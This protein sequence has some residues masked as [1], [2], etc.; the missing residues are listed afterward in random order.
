MLLGISGFTAPVVQKPVQQTPSQKKSAQKQSNVT[1]IAQKAQTADQ[2]I[3][4]R[5]VEKTVITTRIMNTDESIKCHN[6]FK[7]TPESSD[8]KPVKKAPKDDPISKKGRKRKRTL[9]QEMLIKDF[10]QQLEEAGKDSNF[11]AL[12][13]ASKWRKLWD[14]AN[15]TENP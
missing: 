2:R 12:V 6:K 11:N 13:F 5:R 3:L 4:N 1:S 7:K 10:E 9:V 14:N 15:S 8:K